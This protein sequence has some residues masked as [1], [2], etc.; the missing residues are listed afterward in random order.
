MNIEY[1]S[2]SR[3]GVW[4]TCQ[5]QYKFKYHLKV[6]MDLP[7]KPYFLY[8]K[9]VHKIIEEHTLAGG[10]VSI[11]N[12]SQRCLNGD[13]AIEGFDVPAKHKLPKEY[14]NK[15]DK[16]LTS[17]QNLVRAIGFKGDCEVK[18]N[19]DLDPPNKKFAYGFIDRLIINN[20]KASIIDYKTTQAGRWL[21]TAKNI[22]GDLQ[23]KTYA[24]VVWKEYNI[25]PE[26]ISAS[27]V[28]LDGRAI[29]GFNSISKQSLLDTQD[30][31]L[32]IYDEIEKADP[33][34]ARGRI[35]R[36]CEFCDYCSI[37]PVFKLTK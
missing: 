8:G 20:G 22:T 19:Y 30:L 6:K 33:E 25:E 29:T 23:L 2:V 11:G 34:K 7:E 37:C 18:F 17:Y 10:D 4:K 12:I 28:Y 36:H 26:N 31:L 27:L 15:L 35:A 14:L 9:L 24:L 32:K 3:S 13:V 1:I 21:K 5:L 16:H